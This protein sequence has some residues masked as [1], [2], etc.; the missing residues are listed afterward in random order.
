MSL[1]DIRSSSHCLLL[2]TCVINK[3]AGLDYTKPSTLFLNY[4]LWDAVLDWALGVGAK[5]MSSG[6]TGYSA[7]IEFYVEAATLSAPTRRCRREFCGSECGTV[8][9]S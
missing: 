3:C 1:C 4:R 7:K 6:Q 8:M 5:S 9:N 2:D